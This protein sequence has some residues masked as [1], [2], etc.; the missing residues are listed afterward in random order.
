MSDLKSTKLIHLKGWLFLLIGLTSAG[1]LVAET[2]SYRISIL[3]FL[4][5]WAFCRFYYY[6]FYVIEKYV[7]S[8]YKFAGLTSFVRYLF[9]KRDA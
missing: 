7:D 8:E 6:I 2:L 4:S 9:R 5:I 3:L 1:L